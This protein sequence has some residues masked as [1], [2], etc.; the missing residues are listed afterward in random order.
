[1]EYEGD[2]IEETPKEKHTRWVLETQFKE[3]SPPQLMTLEKLKEE[4]HVRR[5]QAHLDKVK[6]HLNTSKETAWTPPSP[7][8]T[9]PM[10]KPLDTFQTLGSTIEINRTTTTTQWAIDA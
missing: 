9:P 10:T 2:D 3:P 6:Q 5:V 1:M 8:P 7:L 4:N